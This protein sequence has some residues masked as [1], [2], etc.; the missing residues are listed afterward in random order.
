MIAIL[1][2]IKETA[3][4]AT[5]PMTTDISTIKISDVNLKMATSITWSL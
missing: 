4:L 1:A 5:L 2:I 3:S